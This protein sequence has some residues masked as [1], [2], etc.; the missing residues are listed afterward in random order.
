MDDFMYHSLLLCVAA[1][2]LLQ[3]VKL[4]LTR[5]RA[6]PLPPGPWQLPVIGSVHHLVNVL[7]H[8]ALMDLARAH[9]PLM[10]LWLGE[11]PLVVARPRR[12]RARCSGPMTPTLP[13]GP[14]FLLVRLWGTTGKTSCSPVLPL[15]RR[16]L[17]QAPAALR[18]RDPQPEASALVSPHQRR[19]GECNNV[20]MQ[21]CMYTDCTST[22]H[23]T[24]R[25]DNK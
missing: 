20:A 19:R 1:V 22:N 25:L 2:A 7:P 24:T 23:I 21:N 3:L 14:S 10:M 8:R 11:T 16:L 18:G 9:G 4:A 17:A 5:S 13:P 6:A 15:R 12:R